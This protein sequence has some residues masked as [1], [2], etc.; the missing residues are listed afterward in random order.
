M[1]LAGHRGPERNQSRAPYVKTLAFAVQ[2]HVHDSGAQY[3]VN[4]KSSREGERVGRNPEHGL[5]QG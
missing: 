3:G 1:G 5:L 4:C 2:L